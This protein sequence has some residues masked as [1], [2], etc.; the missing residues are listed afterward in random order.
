[1]DGDHTVHIIHIGEESAFDSNNMPDAFIR[2]EFKV[3]SHG[4]FVER[5]RKKSYDTNAVRAKLD[6]FAQS[7][8]QLAGY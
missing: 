5:F 4:P 1:M 8:S 2:V 6:Q 3:G 7:L